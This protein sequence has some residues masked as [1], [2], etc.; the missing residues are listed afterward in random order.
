MAREGV[1]TQD[2]KSYPGLV[3]KKLI[4]AG[5]ISD[6]LALYQKVLGRGV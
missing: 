1:S 5:E 4:E 6:S 2:L 3:K